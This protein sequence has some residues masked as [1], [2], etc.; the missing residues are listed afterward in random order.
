V[1]HLDLV[2]VEQRGRRAEAAEIDVVDEETDRRVGSALVLLQ[3]A[4]TSNLEVSRERGVAGPIEIGHERHDVLEILLARL[5]QCLR[6]E[7]SDASRKL[8]VRNRHERCG[9]DDFLKLG[10]G[11]RRRRIGRIGW[12]APG[13]QAPEPRERDGEKGGDAPSQA[14]D[15][16]TLEMDSH[17]PS[18]GTNRIRFNGFVSARPR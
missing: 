15:A 11:G 17:A 9:D 3:L 8:L 10:A 1:Q 14:Q 2:D 18:A 5:A 7:D 13:R 6:V 12:K 16:G 4:D